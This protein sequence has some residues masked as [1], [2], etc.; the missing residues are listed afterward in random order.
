MSRTLARERAFQMI[1]E[2]EIQE[3]LPEE[4]VAW[5]FELE[6][7]KNDDE[8]AYIRD[9]VLGVFEHL[10]LLDG[11]IEKHSKNWKISR[12]SKVDLAIL[13]LAVF[14]ILL[15]ADV[16]DEVAANEAVE[17]AKRYADG[18]SAFVNGILSSVIR[19][20]EQEHDGE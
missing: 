3:V 11:Q 4:Q 16:P 12:I 2:L 10:E 19:E 6:P 13:R 15:L 7:C 5:H 9:T 14:E 17:L 8:R 20:K 1:Y 18:S